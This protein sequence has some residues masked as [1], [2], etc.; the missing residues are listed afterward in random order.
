M[1]N[2]GKGSIK[3]LDNWSQARDVSHEKSSMKLNLCNL[4]LK[5]STLLV[6]THP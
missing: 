3:N 1:N 6:V 4:I 5:F 2:I